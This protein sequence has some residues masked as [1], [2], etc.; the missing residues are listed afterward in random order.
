MFGCLCDWFS[1]DS[2]D[3]SSHDVTPLGKQ[4][5]WLCH[6]VVLVNY[7]MFDSIILHVYGFSS[8]I[9]NFQSCN[10]IS[11]HWAILNG[12]VSMATATT[13]KPCAFTCF[14]YLEHD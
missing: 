14:E 11:R 1:L 8:L 3:R 10:K 7:S 9:N 2:V 12:F 4:I 6:H 5:N 13:F